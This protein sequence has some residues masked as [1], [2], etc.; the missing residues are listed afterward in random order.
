MSQK[1]L[2]EERKKLDENVAYV[3][4]KENGD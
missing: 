2:Q 4:A 1:D 3:K